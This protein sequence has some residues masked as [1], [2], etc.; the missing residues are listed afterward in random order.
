MIQID[1]TNIFIHLRRSL[2][3][4]SKKNRLKKTYRSENQSDSMQRLQKKHED[5][6]DR[7]LQQILPQDLVKLV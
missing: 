4:E 5:D 6:V 1:T 2:L 3:K 7:L